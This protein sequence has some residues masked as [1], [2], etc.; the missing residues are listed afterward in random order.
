MG[1]GIG[2]LALFGFLFS[3]FVRQQWRF[4]IGMPS[5]W[6]HTL[7]IPGVS[8]Y[9]IWLHRDELRRVQPFTPCWWGMVPVIL[10][11]GWYVLCVFGPKPLFHHNVMSAGVLL[12]ILGT[13]WLLLGTAAFR[14]LWFPIGYWWVFGQ[15]VSEVLMNRLTFLMQDMSAVGAQFLLTVIGID[16]D[17]SGNTLTVWS[18]GIAHPLNVAEACS[19]MRMLVAFIALGVFLAYTNLT[20]FWQR[21]ALVI[22]GIPVALGVNVLRIGTTG[23]FAMFDQNFADGEFHEFIGFVWLLPALFMYLGVLF[24]IRNFFVESTGR[25]GIPSAV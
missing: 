13:A 1:V 12:S 14:W 17:R 25:K 23:V 4:A 7:V 21:S 19:G 22:A 11:M 9:F 5:D 24:V 18:D 2:L 20:S 10:G 6:G 8:G 15:T 16:I 3:D